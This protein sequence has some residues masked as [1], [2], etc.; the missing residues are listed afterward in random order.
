MLLPREKTPL[1]GEMWPFQPTVGPKITCGSVLHVPRTTGERDLSLSNGPL[2]QL[3]LFTSAA[4]E[5]GGG[6]C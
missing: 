4:G 1:S 5:E 2:A 3:P 6:G